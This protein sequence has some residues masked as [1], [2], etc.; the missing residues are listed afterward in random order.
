MAV[1]W[2]LLGQPVNV[3]ES[4]Q[5]LG[6]SQDRARLEQEREADRQNALMKAA[7][8]QQFQQQLG[9]AINP[10]TGQIDSA[11]ARMAYLN[12]GDAVGAIQFGRDQTTDFATRRKQ[13]AE[14]FAQA[15]MET[16][17]LPDDQIAAAVSG[18]LDEF[19]RVNPDAGQFRQVTLRPPAEIRQFL[20]GILAETG[21]LDDYMKA[22]EPKSMVIPDGGE[23]GFVQNGRR[24]DEP[25][26]QST[27]G[28]TTRV[29][30]GKTYWQTPDGKVYDT[31]PGG[32]QTSASGG[33]L[34]Q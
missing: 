17:N 8:E 10:Q 3:L 16:L 28:V 13:V 31:P 34:G 9:G 6:A 32:G 5:V 29:I 19:E 14:P 20:K 23:I 18:Y 11:A 25:P 22:N 7:Q 30:N 27:G 26:A 21:Y 24:I 12:K 2:G 15:A 4:L 33:F 1:N